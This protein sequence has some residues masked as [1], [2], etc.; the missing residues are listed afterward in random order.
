M[1]S[2][3]R[4]PTGYRIVF[5]LLTVFVILSGIGTAAI[6]RLN[7]I[8]TTVDDVTNHL[9]AERALAD[10][11]VNR[12]SLVRF[13]A[14]RYVR[15]QSQ[16]DLDHFNQ[17]Y[18]ALEAL[19]V[20]ADGRTTNPA[21]VE[22][23]SHLRPAV[24]AYRDAFQEIA[25]LIQQRQ[26]IQSEVLDVEGLTAERRLTA[27]KTHTISLRDSSVFLSFSNAQ[28]AFQLMRLSTAR[29]L[30][31]GDEPYAFLFEQ[32]YEAAEGALL[33]LEA[34]LQD[35]AQRE[36]AAGAREAAS[37]YYEGFQKIRAG[38]VRQKELFKTVLDTRESE[39]SSTVAV[40]VAG[41]EREF[42]SRNNYSQ[43]LIAQT[44]LG[45]IGTTVI[46]ALTGLVLSAVIYRRAT[47]REVA[48]HAL[49]EA[50]DQL[51][52]R[53]KERTDELQAANARLTQEIEE[54][55]RAERAME[56][57]WLYLKAVL[58]AVPDAIV[59]LDARGQVVEWNSS[60]ERLF[61]F[62]RE[63]VV[64]SQIDRMITNADT[65]AEAVKLTEETLSQAGIAPVETVRCRKDGSLVDVILAA[66]PVRVAGA[67]IG[68][69]AIYTDITERKLAEK[70]LERYAAELKQ[71]NE[72]VKHFAY[73][74]SH[75]LRAP[76][77]NLKGFSSELRFA[78]EDIQG[79]LDQAMPHLDEEQRQTLTTALQEDVPEALNFIEFSVTRMDHFINAVLKLSRLGR[80]ELSME[81]IDMN[82]LIRET[83]EPLGHQIERSQV[84]VR[85]EELPV[86][87]ADRTAM[88]QIMGNLLGNALKYL[89][90]G[91]PGV[92]EVTADHGE[93]EV[94]VRVRDNG[95]GI[96]KDDMHKVFAPFRRA[97]RQDVP[98]EGMGLA[99]VQTL[100]RQHGG[101]IWCESELG[102]GTT[103]HLAIP[104]TNRR[105]A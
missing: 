46:A 28:N 45:L 59:T 1:F 84:Q 39:A 37:A 79:S 77:V 98:G 54:R 68:A 92:I 60:A 90:P 82:T 16:A 42:Q 80:R 35:P 97:G 66:S 74:V 20:Q 30:V 76:L 53:V 36:N 14:N 51:E 8:S 29:Y 78:L 73:I 11:I 40:M 72:E 52:I 105:D 99:Y 2:I 103:F 69:V 71:A 64:G 75:D 26:S 91:R 9:A 62:S 24:Q 22:M 21:R 89:E 61:G 38:Y 19:L 13:Y 47:E 6:V 81:P 104:N 67:S 95:R 101:R 25:Q 31:S 10:D 18:S 56:E 34:A 48:A 12:I 17:A 100:V 49:R 58:E 7:Q 85:V 27:L 94:V 87:I 4:R 43:A 33:S 44:R 102:E 93:D 83:L 70:Q 41:V 96:A 32:A 5:G 15:T 63:E 55:T 3:L 65:Y 50:R 88:E 57:R 23:L 86:V